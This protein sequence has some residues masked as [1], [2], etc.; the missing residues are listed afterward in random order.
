LFGAR[1]LA[2]SGVIQRESEVVHLVAGRIAD[3]SRL[4]GVLEVR[5][6]DFR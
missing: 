3:H 4:L 1:L 5:A 2:I 6:R